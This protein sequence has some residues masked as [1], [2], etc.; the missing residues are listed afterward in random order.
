MG[1]DWKGALSKVAPA[2]GR[3]IG[4]PIGGAL[5]IVSSVLLNKPDGTTTE[6]AAALAGATPDQLQKLRD[7]DQKFVMDLQSIGIDY[8]KLAVEDRE[9]ARD[10]QKITKSLMPAILAVI[11]HLILGGLLVALYIQAI[12]EANRGAFDILL[13]AISTGTASVWGFYFGSSAG[14]HSKDDAL[15]QAA[16]K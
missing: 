5:Q 4:G 3:L 14:S 7:A 6:V 9:N 13:G 16:L 12:P 11:I 8:E 1:I 15:A 2:L 10:M